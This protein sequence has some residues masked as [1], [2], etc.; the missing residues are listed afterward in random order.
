MVNHYG[1]YQ[2]EWIKKKCKYQCKLIFWE[3]NYSK[4]KVN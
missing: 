3:E 4:Q 2:C 1:K